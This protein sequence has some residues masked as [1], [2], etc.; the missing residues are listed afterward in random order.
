[1]VVESRWYADVVADVVA[2]GADGDGGD[3]GGAC[4]VVAVVDDGVVDALPRVPAEEPSFVPYSMI[5]HDCKRAFEDGFDVTVSAYVPAADERGYGRRRGG[6]M[7]QSAISHRV[8]C[9]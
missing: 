9:S 6:S 5:C 2:G 3:V 1:M 7:V 8:W 4:G